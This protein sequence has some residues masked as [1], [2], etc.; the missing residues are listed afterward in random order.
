[1]LELEQIMKDLHERRIHNPKVANVKSTK[2]RVESMKQ[3]NAGTDFQDQ[4]LQTVGNQNAEENDTVMWAVE[5]N[6]QSLML[7][8]KSDVGDPKSRLPSSTM[9]HS[10]GSM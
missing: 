1:M 10:I 3:N 4:W 7:K 9:T 8:A 2:E 6:L 5:N